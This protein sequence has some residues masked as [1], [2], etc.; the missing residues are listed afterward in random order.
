[1]F[2]QVHVSL[3]PPVNGTAWGRLTLPCGRVV[4]VACH[5]PAVVHIAGRAKHNLTAKAAVL[6]AYRALS[7][8]SAA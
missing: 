6:S 8:E 4:R 1:M 2:T 7:L 3:A 5:A